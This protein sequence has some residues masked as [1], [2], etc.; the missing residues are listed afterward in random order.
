MFEKLNFEKIQ[1]AD[2]LKEN[3]YI[4]LPDFSD[5]KQEK[6]LFFVFRG[7]HGVP[8]VQEL[9]VGKA[10]MGFGSNKQRGVRKNANEVHNYCTAE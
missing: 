7:R 3:F 6:L 4:S 8:T 1:N 2:F 5:L 9:E 10:R